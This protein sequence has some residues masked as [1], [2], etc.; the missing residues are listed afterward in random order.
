MLEIL[1]GGFQT[2][3]PPSALGAASRA[4]FLD[5]PICKRDYVN[6]RLVNGEKLLLVCDRV[7]ID[8]PVE[9]FKAEAKTPLF[10]SRRRQSAASILIS[11][12]A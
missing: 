6:L 4:R 2:S 3:D 8:G 9:I 11:A 10:S 7:V 1:S 5:K 12:Q